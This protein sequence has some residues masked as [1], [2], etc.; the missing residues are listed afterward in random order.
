MVFFIT[1]FPMYLQRA[2]G[3]SVG[4]SGVLTFYAA[5]GGMLSSLLGGFASDAI[6][7]YTGNR[8]L[9][10]QGIAIAGTAS[11]AVL[12]LLSYFIEDKNLAIAVISL[13]AFC[14]TFGGVSAYTM[15][16]ELGGKQ[17]TTVFAAM[18]MFGNIG[19]MLF[20]VTVG[21]LVSTTGNWNLALFLFASIMAVAALCWIKLN[22]K[23]MPGSELS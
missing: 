5:V 20:P 23:Q 7:K 16:M 3:V 22:P 8:R 11:C 18:N 13:G 2:R 1:W 10:R 12:A 15:A 4:N 14:A 6:L 19:A 9:S 21:W 17:V